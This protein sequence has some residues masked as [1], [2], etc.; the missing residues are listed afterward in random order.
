MLGVLKMHEK[1]EVHV[2]LTFAAE[3][4]PAGSPT[5]SSAGESP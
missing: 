4:P 5:G 2:D 1:I 3:S